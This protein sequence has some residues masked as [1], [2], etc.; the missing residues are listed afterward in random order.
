LAGG[1]LGVIARPQIEAHVRIEEPG[2]VALGSASVSRKLPNR[3]LGA[4]SIDD[5]RPELSASFVADYPQ[6]HEA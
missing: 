5:D 4:Q 1:L 2:G 3:Q 6:S